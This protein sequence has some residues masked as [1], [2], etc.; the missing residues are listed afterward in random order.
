MKLID[1]L[2]Y[3]P[4]EC[5]IGIVYGGFSFY[6][7]KGDAIAEV[8]YKYRLIKEQVE[9]MDVSN[10]YPGTYV[11]CKE[12]HLFEKNETPPLCIKPQIIIEI[13]CVGTDDEKETAGKIKW[14]A[15]KNVVLL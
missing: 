4:D 10:V 7:N 8:A 5:E 2:H 3:I 9:N 1:L 15:H 12:A 14:Y 11:Q 13:E 6:G